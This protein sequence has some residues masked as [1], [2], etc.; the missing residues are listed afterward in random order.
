MTSQAFDARY[1]SE[2]IDRYPQIGTWLIG[3][4]DDANYAWTYLDEQRFRVARWRV[5]T[6]GDRRPDEVVGCA[7]TRTAVYAAAWIATAKVGKAAEVATMAAMVQAHIGTGRLVAPVDLD[8]QYD[9]PK[10]FAE[11]PVLRAWELNAATTLNGLPS[12]HTVVPIIAG[13]LDNPAG[14]I[15]AVVH[16]IEAMLRDDGQPQCLIIGKSG[17]GKTYIAQRVLEH[18]HRSASIINTPL[19]V[20]QG[21]IINT[22]QTFLTDATDAIVLDEL[23]DVELELRAFTG[24][25][26]KGMLTINSKD[27]PLG[28]KKVIATGSIPLDKMPEDTPSR[29]QPRIFIVPPLED[30]REVVD[31]FLLGALATGTATIDTE[32]LAALVLRARHEH[33]GRR[34]VSGW[35]TSIM[36]SAP[37]RRITSATWLAGDFGPNWLAQAANL[38]VTTRTITIQLQFTS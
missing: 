17:S 5:P 16:G 9:A 14:E 19:E 27:T 3:V 8:Q 15:A 32:V 12:T 1:I 21:K 36:K 18:Q 23:L 37:D 33:P 28:K 20:S 7:A 29:Y 11:P 38:G 22:L 4:P 2:A 30:P 31:L 25:L 10:A 26:G 24:G 6:S 34:A 35:G 13:V